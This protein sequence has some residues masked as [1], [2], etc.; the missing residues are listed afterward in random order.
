M[1]D[2]KP[3][4]TNTATDEQRTEIAFKAFVVSMLAG[5]HPS[6]S[7]L[8][9]EARGQAELVASAQ[10]PRQMHDVDRE[11]LESWGLKMN[12]DDIT[13]PLF[14]PCELP[15]GWSRTG[16]PH[17]MHSYIVD[18][19]G[20]QRVGMFYKAA[21]YDRRAWARVIRRYRVDSNYDIEDAFCKK[22]DIHRYDYEGDI[23]VPTQ[24]LIVDFGRLIG[25]G[26]DAR[27]VVIFATPVFGFDDLSDNEKLHG[28]RR[29][30]E[31]EIEQ[32]RT[33]T[34]QQ[35]IAENLP[36]F[37]DA[38]KHWGDPDLPVVEY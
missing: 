16:S 34:T 27:P 37:D 22:H 38:A 32:L 17:S 10:I 7:I 8:D 25:T 21:F 29:S 35:W 31:L 9:Q 28:D 5:R 30:R 4:V 1:S 14:V 3:N 24:N 2:D 20:R 36:N 33:S 6:E 19:K 11:I 12:F 13:D 18:E 15:E 23:L 26:D